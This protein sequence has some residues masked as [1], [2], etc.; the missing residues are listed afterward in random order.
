MDV[1]PCTHWG[2]RGGGYGRNVLYTFGDWGG[3]GRSLFTHDALHRSGTRSR[4]RRLGVY[5]ISTPHSHLGVV[6]PA[7][8]P[9]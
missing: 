1:M 8:P 6:R 5:I 4:G 3:M 9:T 2:T 7:V